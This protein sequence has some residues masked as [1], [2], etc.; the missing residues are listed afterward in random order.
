MSAKARLRGSLPQV[1]LKSLHESRDGDQR[2]IHHPRLSW[3]VAKQW[4][5][6][7][8]WRWA[9]KSGGSNCMKIACRLARR[10]IFHVRDY[11][12]YVI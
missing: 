8:A 7:G 12:A 3:P 11:P 1:H 9:I 10:S 5:R 4:S 2:Y 6:I